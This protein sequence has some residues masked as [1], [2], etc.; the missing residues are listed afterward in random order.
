MNITCNICGKNFELERPDLIEQRI[1]DLN[2]QYYV[3]PHCGKKYIVFA[4]DVEM[5]GLVQLREEYERKI[6][7]AVLKKFRR[8]IIE[9]WIRKND[10][11]KLRQLRLLPTLKKRAA[12]LLEKANDY[13]LK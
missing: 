10:E 5:L 12:G 8:K 6:R 2:I 1:D 7:T 3:C 11:F 9:E 13:N 4:A